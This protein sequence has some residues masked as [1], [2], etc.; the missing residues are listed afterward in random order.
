M[1]S[2]ISNT[3]MIVGTV[4]A[5]AAAAGALSSE[6]HDRARALKQAGDIVPLETILQK[7]R[8]DQPGRVVETEL[9]RKGDRYVYEVKV[10]DDKGA[11][12]E[13]RYDAKSAELLETERKTERR[14]ERPETPERN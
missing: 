11:V 5:L 2:V 9:E 1:R 14:S 7:A 12:R 6:D 10:V 4:G 3:L 8:Q 13:L